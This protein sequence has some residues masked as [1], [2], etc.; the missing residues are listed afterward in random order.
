MRK[1]INTKN[2]RLCQIANYT[3]NPNIVIVYYIGTGNWNSKGCISQPE[4]ETVPI[5]NLIKI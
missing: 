2:Q 5:N 1:Y 4:M 3:T